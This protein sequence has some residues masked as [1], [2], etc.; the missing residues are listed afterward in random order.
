[1]LTQEEQQAFIKR[2]STGNFSPA[3]FKALMA[4]RR[5][6]KRPAVPTQNCGTTASQRTST[7]KWKATELS[8]DS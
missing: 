2:L 5:K 6:K 3:F 4:T 7:V 8:S 1:M